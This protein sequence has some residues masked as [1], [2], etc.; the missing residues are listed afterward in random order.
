M[1]KEIINECVDCGLP[2]LGDSCPKMNVVQFRC[3][4]CGDLADPDEL[5]MLEDEMLCAECLLKR[6]RTA[7]QEGFDYDME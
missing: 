4:D 5:Y 1:A 7:K 2:C 3:D 6:F